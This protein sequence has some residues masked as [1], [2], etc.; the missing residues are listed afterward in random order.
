MLG[1]VAGAA[2]QQA[3]PL[4]G[5]V[6][7]QRSAAARRARLGTSSAGAQGRPLLGSRPP[8]ASQLT[9]AW[10]SYVTPSGET[11]GSRMSACVM[12]HTSS[13]G[14]APSS[15]L[16]GTRCGGGQAGAGRSP[17]APAAAPRGCPAGRRARLSAAAAPKAS[18]ARQ[19]GAQSV[20]CAAARSCSATWGA[21]VSAA[22]AAMP[23]SCSGSIQPNPRRAAARSR[24]CA[25]SA[26]GAAPSAAAAA[27]AAWEKGP[28]AAGPSAASATRR[29]PGGTTEARSCRGW[30][31]GGGQAT[32]LW[33]RPAIHPD[34]CTRQASQ[35]C[36][37][38]TNTKRNTRRR[39]SNVC[40]QS[41]RTGGKGEPW[42]LQAARQR[43]RPGSGVPRLC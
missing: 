31:M 16:G 38:R 4:R 17:P 14:A 24:L 42:Q 35:R 26:G 22:E 40:T 27:A 8:A 36:A 12:G 1:G 2:G 15:A 7:S 20:R 43:R 33:G 25:Q 18:A 9:S 28:L 23:T 37:H 30:A 32:R 21:C 3:Q 10:R 11:A 39:D 19:A 13:S 6:A 34:A 41:T 29:R 5:R